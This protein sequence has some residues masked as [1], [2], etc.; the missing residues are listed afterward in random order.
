MEGTRVAIAGV[1]KGSSTRRGITNSPPGIE[2]KKKNRISTG[3]NT[4]HSPSP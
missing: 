1:A 4:S 3:A 2:K